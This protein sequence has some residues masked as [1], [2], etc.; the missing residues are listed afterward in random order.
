MCTS[1][2]HSEALEQ[3][4]TQVKQTI[5]GDVV[6]EGRVTSLCDKGLGY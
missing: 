4:T 3:E 1:S 2:Y 6:G 5:K